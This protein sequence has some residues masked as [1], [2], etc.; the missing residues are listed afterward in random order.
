M[1]KI[2]FQQKCEKNLVGLLYFF[3]TPQKINVTYLGC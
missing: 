3:Q 2:F 1:Q